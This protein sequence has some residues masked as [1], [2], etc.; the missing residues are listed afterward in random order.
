MHTVDAVPL[1]TLHPDPVAVPIEA[2]EGKGDQSEPEKD[3]DVGI[4][5]VARKAP[6][7]PKERPKSGEHLNNNSANT[8]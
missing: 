8:T 3:E 2:E 5:F 6:D 4:T 7:T 1:C